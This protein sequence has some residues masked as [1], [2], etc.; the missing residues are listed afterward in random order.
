MDT[1]RLTVRADSEISWLCSQ[2]WTAAALAPGLCLEEGCDGP[3]SG[4]FV[5]G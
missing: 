4:V 5:L 2:L 1:S 3:R